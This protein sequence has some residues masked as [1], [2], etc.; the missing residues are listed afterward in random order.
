M[1][2]MNLTEQLKEMR[3]WLTMLTVMVIQLAV[4]SAILTRLLLSICLRLI[5][6]WIY[7]DSQGWFKR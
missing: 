3:A 1:H 2:I 4:S 7:Y 6:S 5:N